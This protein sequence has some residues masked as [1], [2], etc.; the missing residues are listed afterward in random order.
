LKGLSPVRTEQHHGAGAGD[1][2]MA[3]PAPSPIP[4]GGAAS[5]PG[6]GGARCL[7]LQR[8]LLY[9]DLALSRVHD[10]QGEVKIGD[11]VLILTAILHKSHTVH[12]VGKSTD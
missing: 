10:N 3:A 1:R 7:T 2:A 5:S 9:H 12:C 4:G 8:G 11:I 6:D